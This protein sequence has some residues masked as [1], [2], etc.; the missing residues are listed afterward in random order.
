MQPDFWLDLDGN[1]KHDI[2]HRKRLF[3]DYEKGTTG[4]LTGS[5]LAVKELLEMVI[6]FLCARF[7]QYFTLSEDKQV[8][9]NKIL[10]ISERIRE[11]HPFRVLLDHIPEDFAIMLRNPTTGRY[12]LR[13]GMMFSTLGWTVAEKIGKD[14]PSL[15]KPVPDYKEKMELSMDR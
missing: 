3:D 6:Q 9:E 10:G 1:Y 4:C 11:R 14:L 5:E 8:F 13:A 12:H 7:P 15:H 2:A